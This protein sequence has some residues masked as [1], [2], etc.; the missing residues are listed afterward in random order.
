MNG[1]GQ[2]VCL[3]IDAKDVLVGTEVGRKSLAVGVQVLINKWRDRPYATFN[4][5][6]VRREKATPKGYAEW[7]ED[8]RGLVRNV[9]EFVKE[10][11]GQVRRILQRKSSCGLFGPESQLLLC[12]YCVLEEVVPSNTRDSNRESR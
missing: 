1:F 11:A 10:L 3:V 12:R 6:C 2:I 9:H 5:D 7:R 8:I 4:I